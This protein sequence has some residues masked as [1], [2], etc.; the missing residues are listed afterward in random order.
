VNRK[1]GS[2]AHAVLDCFLRLK[3]IRAKSVMSVA[4]ITRCWCCSKEVVSAMMRQWGY[5]EP[6]VKVCW[7]CDRFAQ[8][9]YQ[10][11]YKDG[12]SASDELAVVRSEFPCLS[13]GTPIDHGICCESCNH[14]DFSDFN[15]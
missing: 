13:C 8:F 11:G 6:I 12:V 7:S 1:T 14:K 15:P 5:E 3:N 10:I 2:I 4:V 9:V